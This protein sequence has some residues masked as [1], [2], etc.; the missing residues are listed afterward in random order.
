[1]TEP[2]KLEKVDIAVGE[3]AAPLR[4]RDP[5]RM[6]GWLS[7]LADQPPLITICVATGGIGLVTGNRRLARAG[8]GMLAAELLA[9]ELKGL[10]KHRVNRTRPHVVADGGSYTLE[11]GKDHDGDLNSFPSGH[12]AG[13][14][15]VARAF[16]R[17]YPEHRLYAYAAATAVAAIQIPRC[18][19]YPSDLA[20]GAVIGLIA[21][22]VVES[23][24]RRIFAP[25]NA[26]FRLLLSE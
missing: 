18:Q 20:A 5:V 19:H 16:G 8:G 7:E 15:A 23:V 13:A 9:T 10:V 17:E 24:R 12:T 3:A 14:V 6:L 4:K 22:T 2:S 25:G 11:P 1:M 26:V 21:E